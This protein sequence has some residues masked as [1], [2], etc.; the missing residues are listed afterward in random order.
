ML[1]GLPSWQD[2]ARVDAAVQRLAAG[3]G[4]AVERRRSDLQSLWLRIP[5]Y[6]VRLRLY[7]EQRVMHV[8]YVWRSER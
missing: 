8:L 6:I 7:P 4:G 3:G 2:A 5:G 1:L